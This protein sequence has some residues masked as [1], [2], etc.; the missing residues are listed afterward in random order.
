[1]EYNDDRT[2][3]QKL[4]HPWVVLAK[5]K[6]MSGWGRA[7]GGASWCGWACATLPEAERVESWVRNREEMRRVRITK[8][9]GTR[10]LR[11]ARSCIN[12]HLYVVDA[13]HP[14]LR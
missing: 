10:R 8:T 7:R 12:F 3:E 2:P 1:M 6:F 13:F 4:T 9:E 14:A 11:L 5:D